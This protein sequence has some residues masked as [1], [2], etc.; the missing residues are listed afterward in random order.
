MENIN[1]VLN[2]LLAHSGVQLTF[3]QTNEVKDLLQ[4]YL[5]PF[6]ASTAKKII[7]LFKDYEEYRI[8]VPYLVV[9]YC[10]LRD[11]GK[12]KGNGYIRSVI[13]H[14][15][16][17]TGSIDDFIKYANERIETVEDGEYTSKN[18][19]NQ[20]NDLQKEIRLLLKKYT[21]LKNYLFVVSKYNSD[22]KIKNYR[23]LSGLNV[24]TVC[25]KTNISLEEYKLMESNKRMLSASQIIT[26]CDL[27]KCTPNEL[28]GFRGVHTVVA[29]KIDG[30]I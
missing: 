12:Y 4:N 17:V 9:K 6:N 3:N 21:Y 14:W 27:F 10:L 29:A 22:N 19:Y 5:K 16:A 25:E 1:D 8:E 11:Y 7:W 15:S 30:E 13:N 18:P 24:S 2:N 26:L 20:I 28:L 23:L